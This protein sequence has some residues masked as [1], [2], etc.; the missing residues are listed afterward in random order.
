MDRIDIISDLA[1]FA[2]KLKEADLSRIKLDEYVLD[3]G[4]HKHQIEVEQREKEK[5]ERLQEREGAHKIEW[6][7]FKIIIDVS[8]NQE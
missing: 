8:R 4:R 5:I 7:N 1:L 2:D 3:F 6:G